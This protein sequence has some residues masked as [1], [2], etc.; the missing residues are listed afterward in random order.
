M[1][2]LIQM[3]FWAIIAFIIL[4]AVHEFGHFWV[5]RKLGVKVVRFS[6]GFG[7]KIWSKQGSDGVEYVLAAIP[8]GGYV[9]M[10]DE[11]EAPVAEPEAA[12]AFNRQPLW[13]RSAV[14]LAGPLFNF[15]FAIVAYWALFIYGIPT[16]V[17]AVGHV[18]P[19]SY[20]A[21]AGLD[22]RLRARRRAAVVG[23]G[24]E[25]DVS[26]H[27]PYRFGSRVQRRDLGM[28]AAGEFMPALSHQPLAVG[29]DAAHARVRVGRA[30]ATARQLQC[31]RH[32]TVI[33]GRKTHES[34]DPLRPG[35]S[36]E[37]WRLSSSPGGS[38]SSRSMIMSATKPPPLYRSSMMLRRLRKKRASPSARAR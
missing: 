18:E 7:R 17:P 32:E 15:L 12:R 4:V 13:V 28:L 20:A 38:R 10:L 30:Q 25:R 33:G 5:A 36:R 2:E 21:D 23:A 6:I 22:Q 34:R 9:K 37:I 19:G 27:A 1:F 8:L 31:Q 29:D 11:R 3:L 14:I 16:V 26:R 35:S 24:F